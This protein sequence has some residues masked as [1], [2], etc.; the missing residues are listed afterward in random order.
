MRAAPELMPRFFRKPVE[1]DELVRT[2]LAFVAREPAPQA[3]SEPVV[4]IADDDP[5]S[6]DAVK[7]IIEAAGWKA[8]VAN[9]GRAAV[10]AIVAGGVDA[11]VL[12]LVMPGLD[13]L[14]VLEYLRTR[15]P[16]LLRRTVIVSGLP[17][18]FRERLGSSEVCASLEKPLRPG[19]L[20]DALVRCLQSDS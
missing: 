9:D 18:A 10:E 3:A 1:I 12:D 19:A 20:L 17:A 14:A 7:S 13:G 2:V 15:A 6:A 5:A 16:Q 11:I 4:L 8:K